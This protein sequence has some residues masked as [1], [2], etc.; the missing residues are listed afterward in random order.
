[1]IAVQVDHHADFAGRLG[2]PYSLDYHASAVM[3]YQKWL[4]RKFADIDRLNRVYRTF[5]S[6]FSQVAPPADFQAE[7]FAELPQYLDWVRFRQE[8]VAAILDRLAGSL[9]KRGITGVPLFADLPP[10]F[11]SPYLP[12]WPGNSST[13][14]FVSLGSVPSLEDYPLERLLARAAVV[15]GPF[16]F[17]AGV[18][19]RRNSDRTGISTIRGPV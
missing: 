3:E 18:E 4:S 1:M 17:R 12:L 8:G 9:V 13:F 14:S 5:H 11:R 10:M 16:P 7:S 6:D 15:G 19:G 2:Y